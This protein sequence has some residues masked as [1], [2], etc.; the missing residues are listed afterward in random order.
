MAL[1]WQC[2]FADFSANE[3]LQCVR[4]HALDAQ[5]H[6]AHLPKLWLD[7]AHS[8]LFGTINSRLRVA[9][10]ANHFKAH[11][12]GIQMQAS[13]TIQ[14]LHNMRIQ[15][16]SLVA[17]RHSGFVLRLALGPLCRI[18]YSAHSGCYR[19]K[20]LLYTQQ[21]CGV[22]RAAQANSHFLSVCFL[23]VVRVS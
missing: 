12:T 9:F 16:I 15:H 22:Q 7:S 23:F 19:G 18:G 11:N 2:L 4:T 6:V 8:P 20:W 14:C 17:H 10:V 3:C 21:T 13:C 1:D 5:R